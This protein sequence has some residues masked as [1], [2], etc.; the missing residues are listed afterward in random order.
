VDSIA[1]RPWR[2]VVLGVAALAG[3]FYSLSGYAMA[4]SFTIS[5]PEQ[6]S[7]GQRGGGCVPSVRWHLGADGLGAMLTLIR[8][9]RC[10]RRSNPPEQP[11]R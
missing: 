1:R 8:R 5:N 2:L 9:G 10:P 4:G 11:E 3:L 7:H 6:L